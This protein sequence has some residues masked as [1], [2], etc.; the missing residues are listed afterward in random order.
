MINDALRSAPREHFVQIGELCERR[1]SGC[2]AGVGPGGHGTGGRYGSARLELQPAVPRRPPKSPFARRGSRR[3][4]GHR[5]SHELRWLPLTQAR[6]K[7]LH[8]RLGIPACEHESAA[9]VRVI[10]ETLMLAR[11]AP[12]A[13]YDGASIAFSVV[14]LP[15]AHR[16]RQHADRH[17]PAARQFDSCRFLTDTIHVV[18]PLN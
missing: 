2:Q 16:I 17:Y 11:V 6:S 1:A 8:Q 7:R 10:L 5:L 13:T 15:R 9:P 14:D 18:P 12:R 3:P 4:A